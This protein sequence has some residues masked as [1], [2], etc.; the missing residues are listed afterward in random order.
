MVAQLGEIAEGYF[1]NRE[2]FPF[3]SCR[4][5]VRDGKARGLQE[6]LDR[7]PTRQVLEG[8]AVW[9]VD[10]DKV[11]HELKLRDPDAAIKKA[12]GGF[13]ANLTP[14]IYLGQGNLALSLDGFLRGGGVYSEKS[15]APGVATTPWDIA[16]AISPD[17][18]NG[19]AA[20]I[21]RHLQQNPSTLTFDG[22]QELNGLTLLR[23][24]ADEGP[25]VFVYLVDPARGYL[26]IRIWFEDK[27]GT[28]LQKGC[29]TKV[30]ECSEG[31]WFPERC[32]L[33]WIS[34]NEA[35]GIHGVREVK[36]TEL[37]ADHPPG[38]EEFAI[39]VSE[40]VQVHDCTDTPD[41]LTHLE[42]G[43]E[44][45]VSQLRDLLTAAEKGHV[46]G[47]PFGSTSPNG[48]APWSWRAWGLAANVVIVVVA[49]AFLLIRRLRRAGTPTGP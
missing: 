13:S 49:A 38:E 10:R 23:F 41:A 1:A 42:A 11:R 46:W 22:P 40:R 25:L 28:V 35:D 9:I 3:F 21:Q 45:D 15:P 32:V 43:T 33:L 4:F 30:R 48:S 7:G 37:D 8:D 39:T 27:Q 29:I 2:S 16:G 17:G 5:T 31:R 47:P 12:G 6:A 18:Y 19:P 26:P 24:S 34:G 20:T 44:I 36:L 14:T